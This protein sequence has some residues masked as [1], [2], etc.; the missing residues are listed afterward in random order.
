MSTAEIIEYI[1]TIGPSITAIIS[2]IASVLVSISKFK[3]LNDSTITKINQLTAEILEDNI[4][5][6]E[7][8]KELRRN[9]SIIMEENHQLKKRLDAM[10]FKR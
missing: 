5:T 9:I 6:K 2:L 1:Q 10:Y 3:K 4:K 8:S 7:E